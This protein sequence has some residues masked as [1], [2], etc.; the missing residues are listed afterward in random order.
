V[1][2]L[3]PRCV[4]AVVLEALADTRVVMIMGA[5]QVG[6]STLAQEIG[7]NAHLAQLLTLDDRT[8][9]R[10]AA[11]DPTA[12]IAGLKG[13]VLIDEVQRVPD[14]L[15]AIK[16][17]VDK[18]QR[19]GRFLLTGS[20]N[21]L[22]APKVYEALTGRIEITQLWPLSQVEIE[23]TDGNFVDA[24]FAGQLPRVHE[25]PIGRD[26]FVRRVAQGGY[27]EARMRTGRR[28]DRWFADYLTTTFERDLRDL[29]DVQK[30][31]EI[32]RLF[33]LLAT[34]AA[35]IYVSQNLASSLGIS[36][37]TV[38]S[39]TK[40]LETVF[41]VRRIPAWRPGLGAREIHAPKVHLVDSGLLAHMLDANEQRIG[42]DDQITDKIL[43]NFVAMEILK[44]AGWAETDTRL[45][46]YRDG[47]DEIDVVLES[48]SGDVVAVEVKAAATI[49]PRDYRAI[50]KLRERAGDSFIAGAVIYTGAQT[51]PLAERIWAVPVSGLWNIGEF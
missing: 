41:L 3:F 21:I 26:A 43:E 50:T 34:Q 27:P 49:N 30:F 39:Y 40:L 22:T 29:A 44:H 42:R 20:A 14:L 2:T 1:A 48:R 4:R 11:N 32:P 17:S 7:V 28:R 37:K 12:F 24:L 5:R 9:R 36:D 33:R 47:G 46:H 18:D 13:S 16:E 6:K 10:A 25:A 8:T 35:N 15:F 38:K 23:G 45:Y 51:I 31:E 19:P